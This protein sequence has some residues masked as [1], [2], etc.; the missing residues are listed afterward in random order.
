MKR[1]LSIALLLMTLCVGASAKKPN[2]ATA[3]FTVMPK[4]SCENCEK[5][6]KSNLRFEKGVKSIDTSLSGQTVKVV[7]NPEKT[8]VE[9]IQKGFA[10]IGYSATEVTAC[11]DSNNK[12]TEKK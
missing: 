7:Y 9:A 11:D 6:I 5:K 1:L 8:S 10:K 12:P 2:Q 3:V 4:M